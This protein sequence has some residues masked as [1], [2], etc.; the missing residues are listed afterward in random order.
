MHRTRTK[1]LNFPT[2]TIMIE[3]VPPEA[4]YLKERKK[5]R[6]ATVIL[7]RISFFGGFN[8]P[9]T[10][11]L[12]FNLLPGAVNFILLKLPRKFSLTINSTGNDRYNWFRDWHTKK[13]PKEDI[14]PLSIKLTQINT[15]QPGQSNG[16]FYW[17]SAVPAKGHHNVNTVLV[18]L[19]HKIC[20]IQLCPWQPSVLLSAVRELLTEILSRTTLSH[21]MLQISLQVRK[22][23]KSISC[24]KKDVRFSLY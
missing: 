20:F 18:Y 1:I 9:P 11:W 13:G 8:S 16:H 17:L 15:T 7:I 6:F 19:F 22:F 10:S 23:A 5:L 12:K 4:D 3:Q 24:V 2:K 14:I 21:E